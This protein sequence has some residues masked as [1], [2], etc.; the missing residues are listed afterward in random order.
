[1]D[2]ISI[3]GLQVVFEMDEL[4][5]VWTKQ[6][7]AV[8]SVPKE[9]KVVNR[10]DF[11]QNVKEGN[12]SSEE[13]AG[14]YDVRKRIEEEQM[15]VDTENRWRYLQRL[16]FPNGKLSQDN[17]YVRAEETTYRWTV[18]QRWYSLNE[19]GDCKVIEERIQP[20]SIGW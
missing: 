14:G 10:V 9:M 3:W 6:E 18:L 20:D 8:K 4:Q 2:V 11:I 15:V 16:C 19:V 5:E 12:R 17:L 1:M 13:V 7:G